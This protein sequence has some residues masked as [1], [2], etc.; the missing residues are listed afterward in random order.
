MRTNRPRRLTGVS[1]VGFQRYFLTICTAFRAL[2]F[3]DEGVVSDVHRQFQQSASQF[4]M[5][6]TAYCYM[7]DHFHALLTATSEQADFCELVRRFKQISAFRYKKSRGRALW[8]PGYHERILRDDEV[9]EAVVRYIL[10][11]PIRAGLTK[12]LGEYR[13]AGSEVYDLSSLITACEYREVR[14]EERRQLRRT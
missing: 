8:Q 10:E 13:F 11:N 9:T 14:A 3:E 6:I 1:Y 2:A 5:A 4:D 12:E 7:P